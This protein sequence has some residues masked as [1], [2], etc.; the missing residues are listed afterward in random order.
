MVGL[1]G[2]ESLGDALR[3]YKRVERLVTS[4]VIHVAS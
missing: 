2:E 4:G 1:R 3:A